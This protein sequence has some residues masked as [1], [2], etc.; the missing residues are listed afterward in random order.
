MKHSIKI[1]N[2]IDKPE[3]PKIGEK[4]PIVITYKDGTYEVKDFEYFGDKWYEENNNGLYSFDLDMNYDWHMFTYRC[5]QV[6]LS[7]INHWVN[8]IGKLRFCV[9][10]DAGLCVFIDTNKKYYNIYNIKYWRIKAWLWIKYKKS[11]W[12]VQTNKY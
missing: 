4:V 2:K 12:C 5:P 10:G 6:F 8:K 3:F 7:K 9:C 11:C 1:R